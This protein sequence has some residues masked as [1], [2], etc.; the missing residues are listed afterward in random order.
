MDT[1][2]PPNTGGFNSTRLSA[3]PRPED[4]N[5]FLR[6]LTQAGNFIPLPRR[7]ADALGL[8]CAVL[9]LNLLNVARNAAADDGYMMATPVFNCKGCG[10]TPDR[11]QRAVRKLLDRGILESK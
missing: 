2:W 3:H 6:T 8:D 7:Y 9:V 4:Y 10:L 5:S 1:R 11:E